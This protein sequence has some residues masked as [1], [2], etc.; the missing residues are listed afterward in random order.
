LRPNRRSRV[1]A[2]G[3]LTGAL[4][5][6]SMPPYSLRPLAWV[7]MGPLALA[8]WQATSARQAALG[9]AA[10]AMVASFGGYFWI[11]DMA[12]R[13][14][15]VPWVFALFLQ[16][17]YGTFAEIHFTDFALLWWVM[18]RAAT[19][20]RRDGG[21]LALP[22]G[23]E[24]GGRIGEPA[25]LAAVL[26]VACELFVPRIFPDK[27]GHSQLDLG[28][29]PQAAALVGTH[30]LSF[31]LAWL[32]VGLAALASAARGRARRQALLETA[33]AVLLLGGLAL[34][35]ARY[36]EARTRVPATGSLSVLLVQSNLGD[37]EELAV[38]LGSVTA[39]V[40]STVSIYE[41]LTRRALTVA[42][43]GSPAVDLVIWPETA[44]PSVPRPRIVA[45]LQAIATDFGVPILF[46]AYDS[47]RGAG[48]RWRIYN[49]AFLMQP[50]GDVGEPYYKH[51]LL[52][53]G[54]YVP[55]SDR[56]P[57]LLNL[58]PSPGEFTPGP[59]PRVFQSGG[60]ALTP[61]ICYELLFP[62]LVRR[63]LRAGGEVVVNLTN[64]YW[65]GRHLE[66]HQH[67]ELV[68]MS[69][70]EAGRPVVR[71]TNT[72]ISAAIDGQGRLLARTGVWVQDVLQVTVPVP[73]MSWTPYARWGEWTTAGLAIAAAVLAVLGR[74]LVPRGR[75]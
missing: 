61:L 28:A 26:F 64:D 2:L 30:G 24:G 55:L 69:A 39:A 1:L 38:A 66:P 75:R 48:N 42:P 19:N 52:L 20:R 60:V 9:G 59:G 41:G 29:L 63:A 57:R 46:G 74:A 10:A 31:A 34:A 54:E 6:L 3:A 49:A 58:L 71:A 56:F 62:R 70:I 40:D 17:I 32:G 16:F 65:F 33:L 25:A 45:R 44:V 22:G 8:V 35:G 68:R 11:A 47:D 43:P 4:Y 51:K 53:F 73:P 14:W 23:G 67:L 27:L 36:R 15:Q 72:G 37:P 18:R 50:D 13:F 12:H 7:A 21:Q 5:F